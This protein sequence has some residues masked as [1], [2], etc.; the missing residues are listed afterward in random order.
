MPNWCQN[1]LELI[2]SKEKIQKIYQII[3]KN[4]NESLNLL[5][6]IPLPKVAPDGFN[7][8]DTSLQP[9]NDENVPN[10]YKTNWYS[11]NV[12]FFGTKW[13]NDID[14]TSSLKAPEQLNGNL[15]SLVL[16]FETAWSPLNQNFIQN[17]CQKFQVELQ[18]TFYEVGAG[19]FGAAIYKNG[20]YN[21][22]FEDLEF[23]YDDINVEFEDWIEEELNLALHYLSSYI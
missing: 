11:Y 8:I 9:I 14:L 21:E 1:R 2:G 13:I 12:H 4:S 15:Y 5:K 23:D 20:F 7:R 19:F 10:W 18:L 6:F 3:I 17:F 16:N 22:L